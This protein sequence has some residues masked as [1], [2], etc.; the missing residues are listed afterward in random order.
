MERNIFLSFCVQPPPPPIKQSV[1]HFWNFKR[2]T[3]IQFKLKFLTTEKYLSFD[4]KKNPKAS[5]LLDVLNIW[6][7]W[8]NRPSPPGGLNF[9]YDFYV[10]Q[11]EQRRNLC[12]IARFSP[13]NCLKNICSNPALA[14]SLQ[15]LFF[16]FFAYTTTFL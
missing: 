4:L 16:F 1:Q 15:Y 9:L 12:L 13:I 7:Q 14:S 8:V 2:G 5:K 6:S 10:C 3:I 11:H